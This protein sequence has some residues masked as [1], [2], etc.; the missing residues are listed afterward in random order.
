MRLVIA[1][2]TEGPD[3]SFCAKLHRVL[4]ELVIR[5]DIVDQADALRFA[6]VYYV[7]GVHK[8]HCPGHSH[9]HRQKLGAA[10][11]GRERAL[12]EDGRES[13][14]F[15][16]YAN[17]AGERESEPGSDRRAVDGG[18]GRAGEAAQQQGRIAERHSLLEQ[19]LVAGRV[20]FSRL[21]GEVGAGAESAPR[22]GD[23]ESANA[24]L[25]VRVNGRVQVGYESAV[26]GV[27]LFG[28]IEGDD[29]YVSDP[30][31]PYG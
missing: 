23:Y 24:V 25:F 15:G 8:L 6:R 30:F 28:A 10:V 5:D 22:S 16:G 9:R 7:P 3:A 13:R 14:A 20:A 11:V 26:Y 21:G 18:D 2:A 4:G 1:C 29:T 12:G 31:A 27:H 19:R 17:V